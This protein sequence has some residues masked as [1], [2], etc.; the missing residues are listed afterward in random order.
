MD[1]TVGEI[2]KQWLMQ[3]RKQNDFVNDIKKANE[4]FRAMLDI[5]IALS[6]NEEIIKYLKWL[7]AVSE[8]DFYIGSMSYGHFVLFIQ[9]E[10][11]GLL[12]IQLCKTNDMIQQFVNE[13]VILDLTNICSLKKGYGYKMMKKV[14]SLRKELN[15]PIQL[16]AETEKNIHYFERYGFKDYGKLGEN[17]ETLMI[18]S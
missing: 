14:I 7:K 13:D 9:S 18:L 3:V 2:D 6:G 11:K 4:F 1:K 8:K 15:C 5:N 17:K 10:M 12:S 16:W